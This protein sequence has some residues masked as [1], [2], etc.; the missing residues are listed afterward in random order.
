M[1]QSL[2]IATSCHSRAATDIM[3]R[4]LAYRIFYTDSAAVT[5]LSSSHREYIHMG[6]TRGKSRKTGFFI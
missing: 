1:M 5:E 3:Q 4:S 6:Y 2:I